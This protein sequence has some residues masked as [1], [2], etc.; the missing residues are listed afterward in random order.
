MAAEYRY[1]RQKT[2]KILLAEL[3]I[4]RRD[5]I[6]VAYIVISIVLGKGCYDYAHQCTEST[7][8]CQ[9]SMC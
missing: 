4:S 8:V 6:L 9:A 5:A 7:Q 3:A 1:V 2:E